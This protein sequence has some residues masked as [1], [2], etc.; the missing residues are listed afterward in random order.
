MALYVAHDIDFAALIGP[1]ALR[2]CGE[3]NKRLSSK[4]ELRFGKN[5]SLSVNLETGQAYDHEEKVGGGTL[6]LVS[7]RRGG[8]ANGDATGWLKAEGFYTPGEP[9]HVNGS[10]APRAQIVATY[11]YVD[12]FGEELFQVVRFEP[13]DF[14][15]RRKPAPDDPPERIK[16]G[17]VWSVKGCRQVPYRLPELVEAISGD[18][19][20]FI[21]EGE[22]KADR[23]WSMG[24]P[25]TCN[26]MG[27]GKWNDE[28]LPYFKGADVVI[29]P[30]NDPQATQK[31][32]ALRFH[33]DGRPVYTGRDHAALVASRLQDVASSVRILA[34]GG[35]PKPP[36]AGALLPPKGDIIEWTDAGGTVEKLWA[37]V[38]KIGEATIEPFR[39]R[40][41]AVWFADIDH[42]PARRDWV[43]KGLFG[44]REFGVLWGFSGCGKSFLALDMGL[45]IAEAAIVK[46]DEYRWFGHRIYPGGVVYCAPE[47]GTDLLLRMRAWRMH[48]GVEPGTP[49]PFVLLPT[50][51]DLVNAEGD[52]KPLVAEIKAQ[53]ARMGVE[54]KLV[55]VDTLARSMGGRDENTAGDMGAFIR[56]CESIQREL[57]TYVLPVHHAGNDRTKERGHTSLRAAVDTSI[58]TVKPDDGGPNTFILRKMKGGP[59]GIQHQFRLRQVVLGKDADGDDITSCVIVPHD[60][61]AAPNLPGYDRKQKGNGMPNQQR[62]ALTALREAIISHGEPAPAALQLPYGVQVVHVRAWKDEFLRRGFDETPNDST[63]RNA[64]K[65]VGEAMLARGVIGRDQ[66]FVWIVREPSK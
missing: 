18:N 21:V 20:V 43:V 63:F 23:L 66:P 55:I 57:Q 8:D 13:K 42:E 31:D 38:E 24:I 59:E 15:Q 2:L 16:G 3:P 28:L 54:L 45:H 29:L 19:T 37:L 48:H 39:S 32:G 14:R 58:E 4:K 50:S 7:H 1:V 51:F 9:I 44:A 49:L 5:G 62:I 27:A 47:G 6:W 41:N 12:E 46:R 34:L 65:R 17:W 36:L 40:Y 56:N 52:T 30:D 33:E 61:E 26:A 11:S 10:Q 25:A 64:F 35:E 22:K 60:E 53:S